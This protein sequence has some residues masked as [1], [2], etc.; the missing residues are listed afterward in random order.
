[1]KIGSERFLLKDGREAVMRSPEAADA[2]KM[3]KYLH[4]TAQETDF[5]L[6]TPQESGRYSAEKE[7]ELFVK[8]DTDARSAMV[9]C[10][11][12]GRIAGVCHISASD[13]VKT[14]HRAGIGIAVLK[15]FWGLGI[16][17]RLLEK[18]T[19]IGRG[20]K[21]VIQLEL[22]YIEGNSRACAL[23]E[24]AGFRTVGVHPNAVR[25]RDGALRH[26][27]LMIKKTE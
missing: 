18:I 13:R 27:Y 14:A 6:R 3:L 23:Y 19:D 4:D 1:M 2:E 11:V 5:L 24:K 17:T 9:L 7:R 15:E 26:E 25:M 22:E 21:G 8:M 12:E 16:G 20:I 10:L